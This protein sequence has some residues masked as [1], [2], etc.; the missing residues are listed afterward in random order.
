VTTEIEGK[1]ELKGAE[2]RKRLESL[3]TERADQWAPREKRNVTYV[4]RLQSVQAAVDAQLAQME[5]EQPSRRVG[6]GTFQQ[7]ELGSINRGH[8]GSVADLCFR[9]VQ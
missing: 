7:L 1:H 5:Q 2:A 8:I 3:N 9:W 4:S 6:L